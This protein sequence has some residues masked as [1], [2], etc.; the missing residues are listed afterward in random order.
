MPSFATNA[1]RKKRALIIGA[2]PA[3]LT[4]AY[5]LLTR[6][7]ILPIVLEK[8][9]YMGGLSRTVNY[10]GNRMD[11]GGHRFFSKSDRVMRWWLNILPLQKID[12]PTAQIAC[13]RQNTTVQAS[14]EGADPHRDEKVMLVRNRK[15]RIYFMRQFFAYPITLSLDTLGKLGIRRT[16]R[17][18]LSYLR[19]LLFPI[20]NE[21]NLEEFFIN[22]FGREL[23]VTFFKSYTEKVW[24]IECSQINAE[25]GAQRIKGLS[26]YKTISHVVKKSFSRKNKDIGQKNVETSLMEQFLYPKY[27]PGQMWEEVAR[28]VTAMGGRIL[29]RRSIESMAGIDGRI[30]SVCGCNSET[31]ETDCFEADYFF[32][33]MPIK[34]L[35]AGM[36]PPAP[37]EIRE[38]S[39]GLIYRDFITVGVLCEGLKLRESSGE[40]IKDNWIYIQ[41][42]DVLVG[43]LQIFNNWSPAMVADASKVWIGLEYF[44][45]ETDALWNRNDSDIVELAKSEL[46][47]M[48][49]VE[50]EDVMDATVIRMPKAY[51]AYFGSYDRFPELRSWL[52]GFENL[53]LIGRNGMHKY[54][55][56]DH[57]MLTAM[58]AVDN[59]IENVRSRDNLWVLNTEHE[60]HE[61]RREAH[62]VKTGEQQQGTVPA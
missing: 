48:N 55:N 8:S 9:E 24:G 52:D 15:S 20:R 23:Y 27:G 43:R 34:E 59:I 25:W 38:I 10:K 3:G 29:T 17:I 11:I 6:T 57:S 50:P 44:C 49:I 5:E 58:M 47:L 45:N 54:N 31:G 13:G 35:V 61:E 60:Y 62:S 12:A 41:E 32:S 37:P 21:Q 1:A 14:T 36:S 30:S 7:E 22:R 53:F 19:A 42:P 46:A 40:I 51:P 4:A 28:Q 26:I 18:G 16:L 56:Q 39:D 2:G 33:T